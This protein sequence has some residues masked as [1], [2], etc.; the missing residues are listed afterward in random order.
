VR[1][2]SYIRGNG[3]VVKVSYQAAVA[4]VAGFTLGATAVA[5]ADSAPTAD[6]TTAHGIGVMHGMMNGNMG[7]HTHMGPGQGHMAGVHRS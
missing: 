5:F 2:A 3:P 6:G 7:G 4:V 1:R